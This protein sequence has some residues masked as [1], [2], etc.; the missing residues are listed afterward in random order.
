MN[1]VDNIGIYSNSLLPEANRPNADYKL[2]SKTQS[3]YSF[4]VVQPP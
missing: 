3:E 4:D 2:H 1:K